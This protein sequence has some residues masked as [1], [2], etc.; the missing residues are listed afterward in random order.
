[1]QEDALQVMIWRAA[2][3]TLFMTVVSMVHMGVFVKKYQANEINQEAK[4]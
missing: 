3:T 2:T 1:M 4:H